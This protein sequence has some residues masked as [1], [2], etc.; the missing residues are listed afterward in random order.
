MRLILGSRHYYPGGAMVQRNVMAPP[1]I[2]RLFSSQTRPSRLYRSPY[3]HFS[4]AVVL[5]FKRHAAV[6]DKHVGF[7]HT[8][9]FN[10]SRDIMR[11]I[12]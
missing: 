5:V 10:I 8:Y 6:Y 12:P 9:A 7:Q 4:Q 2:Y 11:Q 1:I 3:G